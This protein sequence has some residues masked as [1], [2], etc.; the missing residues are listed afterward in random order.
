MTVSIMIKI[1]EHALIL[2][3]I[4]LLQVN[5]NWHY[6]NNEGKIVKGEQVINGNNFYFDKDGKQVKGNFAEKMERTMMKIQN[7]QV[8]N[9]YVNFNNNWYRM[10]IQ[11]T[12]LKRGSRSLMVI[13]FPL[14]KTVNRLR[15]TSLQ[16]ATITVKN[17][18][19][20]VDLGQNHYQ[21]ISNN[22]YYI[23]NDGNTSY[24]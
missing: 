6:L 16:M 23:G 13:M 2:A 21:N 9:R 10:L 7:L 18:G 24:W 17:S 22:W 1:L 12:P 15:A 3:T 8:T 20:R 14:T 19:D 4:S 5:G 11:G